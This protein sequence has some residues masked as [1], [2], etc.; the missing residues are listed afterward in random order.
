MQA[1][2]PAHWSRDFVE[3]LRTVHFALIAVSIGLILLVLSSKTYRPTIALRQ[4]EEVIQLQKSRSTPWLLTYG[5]PKASQPIYRE[6][7]KHTPLWMIDIASRPGR[8]ILG[9]VHEEGKQHPISFVF[10]PPESSW[11]QP[12]DFSVNPGDDRWRVRQF[13]KTIF[14]FREW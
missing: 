9:T 5:E 3:H 1:S 4:I 13:P 11:F 10:V 6:Y 8:Q 2:A 12:E 14:E 7:L